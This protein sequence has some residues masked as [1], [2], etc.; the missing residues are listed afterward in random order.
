MIQLKKEKDLLKE[1][2]SHLKKIVKKRTQKLLDSTRFATLGIMAISIFHDLSNFLSSV[3][4]NNQLINMSDDLDGIKRYAAAEDK[5][6]TLMKNYLNN[7][8][9]EGSREETFSTEVKSD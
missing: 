3:M 4:G 2:N 9:N 1:K 5:A 8:V 7:L 6:I